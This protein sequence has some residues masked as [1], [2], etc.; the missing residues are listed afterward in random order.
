MDFLRKLEKQQVNFSEW[1]ND[2]LS[3]S[4]PGPEFLKSP[5]FILAS[6]ETL[7]VYKF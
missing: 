7:F 6:G 2:G 5:K 1:P 3:W 4:K